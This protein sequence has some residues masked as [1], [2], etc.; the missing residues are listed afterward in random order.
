[1]GKGK[2]LTTSLRFQWPSITIE[3]L[4]SVALR[5]GVPMS[6]RKDKAASNGEWVGV[7]ELARL[8]HPLNAR[9]VAAIESVRHSCPQIRSPEQPADASPV[10]NPPRLHR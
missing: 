7:E 10:Q 9:F 6:G 8:N 2:G 1:V 5:W 3:R 4:S